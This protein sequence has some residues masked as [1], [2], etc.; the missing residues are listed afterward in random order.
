MKNKVLIN[1]KAIAKYAFESL[2]LKFKAPNYERISS[3]GSDY[4]HLTMDDV[5]P[6]Q[7]TVLDALDLSNKDKIQVAM[8]YNE[9]HIFFDYRKSSAHYFII[10]DDGSIIHELQHWDGGFS[11][12]I[13][14]AEAQRFIKEN[15][16][17]N[18]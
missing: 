8:H 6:L 10:D 9:L 3:L 15:F 17:T 5:N 11:E 13:S 2:A 12:P 7:Q 1:L 14:L 18:E 4:R 16:S